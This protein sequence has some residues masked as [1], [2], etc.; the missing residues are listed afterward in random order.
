MKSIAEE[1]ALWKALSEFRLDFEELLKSIDEE[2]DDL[3]A[4]ENLL[5]F[6]N[7]LK[8]ATNYIAFFRQFSQSFKC[9]NVEQDTCLYG[10][11][12]LI[13]NACAEFR[14]IISKR[15]SK[16][17]ISFSQYETFCAFLDLKLDLAVFQ[18]KLK[19]DKKFSII[20]AALKDYQDI[21]TGTIPQVEDTHKP[22]ISGLDSK[23]SELQQLITLVAQ[24]VKN[25]DAKFDKMSQSITES[26]KNSDA[27]FDKMSQS[28]TNTNEMLS[29]FASVVKEQNI[30]TTSTAQNDALLRTLTHTQLNSNLSQFDL[31]ADYRFNGTPEK[32]LFFL[33]HLTIKCFPEVDDHSLRYSIIQRNITPDMLEKT[34]N[35]LLSAKDYK[36][37]VFN[38]ISQIISEFG[39]RYH[40]TLSTIEN[41][42]QSVDVHLP[43]KPF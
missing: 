1:M 38:F 18:N 27:K 34:Q 20:F 16:G 35:I 43:P 41:F 15:C 11:N 7:E 25:S 24:S 28:I 14:K 40:L 32:L 36:T 31:P 9:K 2:F 37:A 23:P 30:S 29:Q 8:K 13:D 4:E 12:K 3:S 5:S 42:L 26:V 19:S 39:D 22:D 17:T 6:Q 21:D 10:I 33:R